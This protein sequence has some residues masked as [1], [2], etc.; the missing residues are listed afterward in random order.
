MTHRIVA[1]VVVLAITSA[2]YSLVAGFAARQAPA[3]LPVP[4]ATGRVVIDASKPGAAIPPRLYGIF[5]EEI[6]HAGDGGLYAELVR[7]RGFEDANLPPSC[8]REGN[9]IV[10]PRTPHFDTGKPS[11]WRLRWDETDPHPAWSLSL[12]S[13]SAA[14]IGLVAD[15]PLNDATP[16]SLHIDVA[17][18]SAGRAPRLVNAGHWGMNVVQGDRYRLSFFARNDAPMR[19]TAIL[20]SADGRTI[21]EQP[22][23]IAAGAWRRQEVMLTAGATEAKGTLA[24]RFDTSGELWLDMISLFPAKTFKNRPNGMRADLAQVIADMKPGFIR[25]PGGCFA[26]GITIESRPQWKRS[27]GPIEGRPGTYSP[28]GYWST[29]GLGYHEFLQFAEDVNADALWVIN[30]GVSCSFR[31]GTFLPDS[32]LPALIQDSLDAI[33]YAIGP[34]TSTLGALRA[35]HGHPAPFPLKYIEIGNEQ[36]GA[37]YG[38]RVAQFYKA[39]KAKYPQMHIALSSWIAGLDRRAID[40]VGPIDI[41]DEH[42]YKPVNWAIEN[43]GSFDS[44]KREGWD[45]YIGE[46]ATNAGVGRG[47]W[48]AAINDAAYMM[49]VEKNTDLVKMA[50]YAPLLENVNKRDWEVNMIHFDSSR[51][52]ARASYYVQKLFAEHL[53]SVALPATVTFKPAGEKAIAGPVG[54]GTW[55]TAAEFRD[56]RI[57]RDGKTIYQSDF[58]RPPLTWLPVTGRDQGSRGTWSVTDGAYRQGADA[59]GFSFLSGSDSSNTTISLKARKISG[60]EGFLVM[61][62][63]VDGRRVQWNV[64]GWGNTQSAIQASDAIVGRAVRHRVDTG[65]WYDLRLELR[66]RTVRGY[67]DGVLL[68]EATYPRIDTVLAIA[69]RDA[70]SGEV[71]IKALNTGPDAASVTFDIAGA[72]RVAATGQLTTL[73]S[74]S[75]MDENSFETPSKIVPVASTVTGLGKSFT[76]TLPPYS[77][78]ILRVGTR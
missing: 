42:A 63:Q 12:P 77:L 44:Y 71:I 41:I 13:G 48:I 28:W 74:P 23:G 62:G 53:P 22:V 15:R 47:N 60:A 27:L 33:E 49:N 45:L 32:E 24:L 68:N 2:G 73:S 46:F 25:G 43:F 58:Q 61:G 6:N 55:N 64:A 70:R 19:V 40:A 18:T 26:E 8:V 75:P 59:I 16:H 9:F 7:N 52:F 31:S 30:V 38:E 36:Q 17:A 50:S 39:I 54:V 20:Q 34:T 35:K 10:P 21:A 76:R 3:P 67:I 66:G 4:L 69:G 57:E 29:D 56:F 78:S 14:T 72:P 51:I 65:R 11:D 37:R 5:Y 1:G